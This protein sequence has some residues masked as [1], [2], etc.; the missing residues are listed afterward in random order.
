MTSAH[1]NINDG[2]DDGTDD[3]VDA[4]TYTCFDTYIQASDKQ[5]TIT[6]MLNLANYDLA[7]A[8]RVALDGLS[9]VTGKPADVLSIVRHARCSKSPVYACVFDVIDDP[10]SNTCLFCGQ[11]SSA[12]R[13]LHGLSHE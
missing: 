13:F 3:S 12:S 2:T 9:G 10:D 5:R 6:H 11:S 7:Q 4:S 1:D 8:Q